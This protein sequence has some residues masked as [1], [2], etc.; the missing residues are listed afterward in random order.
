MAHQGDGV[1]AVCV[2]A[3]VK[4]VNCPEGELQRRREVRQEFAQAMVDSD[5]QYSHTHAHISLTLRR[6]CTMGMQMVH[7]VTLH[8]IDV[9]NSRAQGFLAL[10]A[11]D[12]GEIKSEVREQIDAKVAEW[13]EEGKA[14]IV[15]GVLFIDEVH[16]LDIEVRIT[17]RGERVRCL[18]CVLACQF[19]YTAGDGG[20]AQCFSFLNRALETDLAPILIMASNRGITR[21]RG[22]NHM[23][24]HGIPLD[25]L[26]RT[27]IV[28]T[29][30]YE[31]A[32]IKQILSIR[33][34]VVVGVVV[35]VAAQQGAL[36]DQLAIAIHLLPAAAT[37]RTYKSTPRR[38][39]RWR[40]S[41]KGRH[42]AMRCRSS[43]R[44]RS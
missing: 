42:Y 31:D 32:E 2:C 3:Q 22:T 20:Y 24:P 33:Y 12:T 8:E 29:S 6:V 16:M 28:S 38:W 41:G 9:I 35:V 26:D 1:T 23:S 18:A 10:F 44:R 25:L 37:R 13:K 5:R 4:F 15:P 43:R 39:R 19:A 17:E 27:L 11:G 40:R 21:I 34:V 14:E 30:A 7:N 36:I